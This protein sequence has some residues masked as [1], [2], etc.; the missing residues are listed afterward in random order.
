MAE[1]N[2]KLDHQWWTGGGGPME[3]AA[4]RARESDSTRE[5]ERDGVDMGRDGE[6]RGGIERWERK[7][8]YNEIIQTRLYTRNESLLVG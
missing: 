3:A 2:Q 8:G 1:V 7:K 5:Q 4:D 6:V